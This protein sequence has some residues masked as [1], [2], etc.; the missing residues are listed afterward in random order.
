MDPP[1]WSD[2]IALGG[3]VITT[4]TYLELIGER[5][6]RERLQRE[7]EARKRAEKKRKKRKRK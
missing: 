4:L 3:L 7:L 1:K 5:R 2:L 6:K